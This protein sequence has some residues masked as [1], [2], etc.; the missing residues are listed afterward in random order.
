MW[1]PITGTPLKCLQFGAES[2]R[3]TTK[4]FHST[5]GVRYRVNP[6]ECSRFDDS[7]YQVEQHFDVCSIKCKYHKQFLDVHFD[8][9]FAWKHIKYEIIEDLEEIHS[10]ST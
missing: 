2:N 9:G 1:G 6:M 7:L 3:A 8:H 5:D 10:L 4:P